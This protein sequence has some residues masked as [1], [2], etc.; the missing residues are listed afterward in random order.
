MCH[1]LCV[2]HPPIAMPLSQLQPPLGN[3]KVYTLPED[4]ECY[5]GFLK[6]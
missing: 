3:R 5:T 6:K 4:S 1:A 2:Q